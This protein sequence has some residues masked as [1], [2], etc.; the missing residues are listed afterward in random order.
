MKAFVAFV[1][2]DIHWDCQSPHVCDAAPL[3]T[4]RVMRVNNG[5]LLAVTHFYD[6]H[7][8]NQAQTIRARPWH[9]TAMHYSRRRSEHERDREREKKAIQVVDMVFILCWLVFSATN[10]YY[11]DMCFWLTVVERSTPNVWV[12]S[13]AADAACLLLRWPSLYRKWEKIDAVIGQ[14]GLPSARS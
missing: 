4:D 9:H 1:N 14:F 3:H 5:C 2:I 10:F 12:L 11:I 8:H 13:F 7:C 6:Y